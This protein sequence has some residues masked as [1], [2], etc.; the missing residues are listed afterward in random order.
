MASREQ[1]QPEYLKVA[2]FSG[3]KPAG[4]AYRQAEE[5]LYRRPDC[6]LSAFRFHLS[7]VWHVAVLGDQPPEDID[8]QLQRILSRG[9]PASLPAE[10]LWQLL[11]RRSQATRIA[12]WVEKHSRPLPPEQ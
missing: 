6:D 11:E 5:L 7:R 4:R 10:V 8:Q 1:Q 3:E 9:Q 12:P 2:S